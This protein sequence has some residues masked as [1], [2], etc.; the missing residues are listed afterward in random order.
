MAVR[1]RS[2]IRLV[3]ITGPADLTLRTGA[4]V[5]LLGRHRGVSPLSPERSVSLEAGRSSLETRFEPVDDAGD[6]AP[7]F[8]FAGF[9]EV[10]EGL[11]LD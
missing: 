4:S 11:G 7:V 3:R 6:L 1:S 5:C 9:D 2:G 10:G 8:G